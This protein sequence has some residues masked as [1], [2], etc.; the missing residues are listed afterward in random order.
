MYRP[1]PAELSA[2][3]KIAERR[4]RMRRWNYPGKARVIHPKY[5][6]L[7]VP[8]ASPLSALHCAAE[9]WGVDVLEITGDGE[10]WV[11]DQTLPAAKMPGTERR[12]RHEQSET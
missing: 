7:I 2:R 11:C 6:E 8:C 12:E 1:E 4:D 3:A 10:V 9:V 5:G